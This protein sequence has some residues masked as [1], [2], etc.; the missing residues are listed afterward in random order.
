MVWVYLSNE[1]FPQ[2]LS[3]RTKE[4]CTYKV[5]LHCKKV[6]KQVRAICNMH[7]WEYSSKSGA[8]APCAKLEVDTREWAPSFLR[9]W[10]TA[11][12]VVGLGV[13]RW[14]IIY[15]WIVMMAL[16]QGMLSGAQ[17]SRVT[18]PSLCSLSSCTCCSDSKS[19]ICLSSINCAERATSLSLFE[20]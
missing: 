2:I 15:T 11:M 12:Q 6:Y 18:S 20:L 13:T 3:G 8:A 17:S 4:A 19:L 10:W 16:M 9:F 1:R 14:R 7:C 5:V